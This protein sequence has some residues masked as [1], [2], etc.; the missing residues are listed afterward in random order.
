MLEVL[1]DV[2]QEHEYDVTATNNGEDA[3]SRAME[4]SFDLIIADIRME[5]MSGLDA[6]EKSR[7]QQPEIGTLIVSGY[8]TPDNMARAMQLQAGK[9]LS[10][11]FKIKDFLRRVEEQLA[12]RQK[13]QAKSSRA[14]QSE[15]EL[16]WALNLVSEV[17]DRPAS[18]IPARQSRALA[19]GLA[20][21]AGLS[22]E[23]CSEVGLAAALASN[24]DLVVP[25]EVLNNSTV[26]S[27]LKYCLAHFDDPAELSAENRLEARL[28]A[29]ALETVGEEFD[30]SDPPLPAALADSGAAPDLVQLYQR[31]LEGGVDEKAHQAEQKHLRSAL[32]LA[33]TLQELGRISAARKAFQQLESKSDGRVKLNSL[34]GLAQ[35]ELNEGNHKQV[36][37]LAKRIVEVAKGL[38]PV[39]YA[40]SLL[41]TGLLVYQAGQDASRVLKEAIQELSKLRFD[42]SVALAAIAMTDLGHQP[43]PEKLNFF[44]SALLQA[45]YSEE[46]VGAAEWLVPASLKLLIRL[47]DEENIKAIIRLLGRLAPSLLAYLQS[48]RATKEE[49][50]AFLSGLEQNKGLGI[51]VNSV[52]ELAADSD[53][54]ISKR[55]LALKNAQSGIAET[56]VI[57]CRSFGVF[58]VSR[59][60]EAVP[61]KDW[62][63]KKVRYY[64]AYLAAQWG[65]FQSDDVIIEHFWPNK[66][67]EKGK[68]NL[69]WST[70][71]LRK[72]VAGDDPNLKNLLERREESLRLNPDILYWHDLTEFEKLLDS[73][74]EA[75]KAKDWAKARIQL[76]QMAELKTGPYLE[77]YRND[78]AEQK[79]EQISLRYRE[80][81]K[82]LAHSCIQLEDYS[83]ALEA[84]LRLLELDS[85]IETGHEYAMRAYIGLANYTRAIQQYEQCHRILANEYGLE[86]S[87]ELLALYEE[88]YS[89][90]D[91]S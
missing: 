52:E 89:Y 47:E 39:T 50:E 40:T 70:S 46:V 48:T 42:G 82:N 67:P 24:P 80:G 5:G 20:K 29:F 72:C 86:P 77:G 81:L 34:L 83:G 76:S 6:V 84:A 33:H 43:N 18:R 60:A 3:V 9:I 73:G 45:R 55:A 4:K 21:I 27:T 36:T 58:Q 31:Y 44:L 15:S 35:L 79:R 28:V 41:A 26:L 90:G 68:Q 32:S 19:E 85:S 38:G 37:E 78:W 61:D 59:G 11:P 53:A 62:K 16:L 63:T 87:P 13:H 30:S 64:F 54:S 74:S 66:S 14:D 8:T 10:K 17:M 69:Y 7:Q 65:T 75:V 22:A 25:A 51:P 49:K 2:L 88:A 1:V 23:V 91:A 57:R 12:L 71:I 56:Q